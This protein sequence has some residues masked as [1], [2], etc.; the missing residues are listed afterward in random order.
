M[1]TIGISLAD[2]GITACHYDGEETALIPLEN[3]AVSSPGYAYLGSGGLLF[4]ER[5]IEF[6]RLNPTRSTDLFWDSLSLQ[7]AS[8]TTTKTKAISQAHL[9]YLHL[10]T[11]WERIQSIRGE[12]DGIGMAVPGNLLG[13]DPREEERLGILLGIIA[14]LEIPLSVLLPLEMSGLHFFAPD[15]LV[16][17][18][19]IYHID[20]YQ[21]QT[22]LYKLEGDSELSSRFLTKIPDCGFHH[23]LELLHN[24]LAQRFLADTAFDISED[25]EVEQ[26]FFQK[27]RELLFTE[28]RGSRELTIHFENQVRSIQV[29]EDHLEHITRS[30]SERIGGLLFR[31]IRNDGRAGPQEPVSIQL[32]VRAAAIPGLASHLGRHAPSPVRIVEA[33]KGS[34]GAGAAMIASRFKP[35]VDLQHT[36]LYT[37]WQRPRNPRGLALPQSSSSSLEPTHLVFKSVAYPIETAGILHGDQKNGTPLPE[38]LLAAFQFPWNGKGLEIEPPVNL[39][40]RVNDRNITKSFHLKTGDRLSISSGGKDY[41][42]EIIHCAEKN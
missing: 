25:S 7:P 14:D 24:K 35:A 21:Y 26:V 2:P 10:K 36:P 31:E 18:P 20:V 30:I 42:V 23:I 29:A 15:E 4:G 34:A 32:S 9:A 11:I 33:E 27:V 1:H 12:I 6:F 40:L 13:T 16:D 22:H 38:E 19:V 28:E 39:S 8:I 3:G 37:T 17:A 5:A 41:S